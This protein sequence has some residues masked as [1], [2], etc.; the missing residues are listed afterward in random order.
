MDDLL[1]DIT[2]YHKDG[3]QYVRYNKIASV[4]NTSYLNRNKTGTQTTDNALIR[5]FDTNLYFRNWFSIGILSNSLLLY[6][7]MIVFCVV[8]WMISTYFVLC[9]E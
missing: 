8:S 5:V 3:T 7:S 2:I 9:L 6:L 4:R 1:Q